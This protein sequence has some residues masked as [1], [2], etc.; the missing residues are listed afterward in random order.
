MRKSILFHSEEDSISLDKLAISEE[1]SISLDK[2]AILEIQDYINMRKQHLPTEVKWKSIRSMHITKFGMT[3]W[4][5]SENYLN[6][7]NA[8][9]IG[10]FESPVHLFEWILKNN[11]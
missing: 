1:D 3:L 2:L 9:A 8:R 11:K 10:T 4:Q 7:L 6:A 5:I